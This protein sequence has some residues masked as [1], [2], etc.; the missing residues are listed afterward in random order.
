MPKLKQYEFSR[1]WYIRY[2]DSNGCYRKVSTRTSDKNAAK[3]ILARFEAELQAPPVE[4]PL[5]EF[6]IDEWLE[7]KKDQ[8]AS[9]QSL[10]YPAKF[11]KEHFGKTQPQHITD[12]KVRQYHKIMEKKG[13]SNGTTIK[14]LNNL[15]MALNWAKD[16]K[17]WIT[18]VPHI[19]F[20]PKPHPKDRWLTR[21]EV[22]KLLDN[23]EQPHIRLFI[24]LA[25]KTGARKSAIL[26]LTW[27]RVSFDRNLIF[28]PLPG[29]E[30]GKKRR[31]IVPLSPNL[32]KSL[33]EAR[34]LARSDWVIEYNE[35]PVGDI[36]TAWKTALK[37]SGIEHCR[38]HDL[39][40]TCATWLIQ[41]GTS[42]ERV[43]RLI[44]DSVHMVE[45]VYGHHAPDYL[46]DAAEAIDW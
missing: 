20:P 10:Y 29:I 15:R 46:K 6:I 35:Q 4:E 44:G 7:A 32:R 5:T 8:V 43:A 21:G 17:K 16:K 3:I 42:F 45:R 38:I 33:M 14:H 34:E 27:D 23:C 25:V 19:A 28:Y 18:E 40:H 36:K 30:H 39:R 9:W 11:L 13:R 26:Q 24:E 12:L 41:K 31:A 22:K 37:A 1:N 2:K